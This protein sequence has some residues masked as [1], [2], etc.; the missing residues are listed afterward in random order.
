MVAVNFIDALWVVF[1]N[2]RLRAMKDARKKGLSDEFVDVIVSELTVDGVGNALPP[3]FASFSMLGPLK[4]QRAVQYVA[5]ARVGENDD[6]VLAK[7]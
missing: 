7:R 3:C 2:R 1:G 6:I 5:T 4:A